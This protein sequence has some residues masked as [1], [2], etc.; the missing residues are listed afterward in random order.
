MLL[1]FLQTLQNYRKW[2]EGEAGQR[3]EGRNEGRTKLP[4]K[5]FSD[6]KNIV[7]YDDNE[8]GK[9][10]N[11]FKVYKIIEIVINVEITGQWRK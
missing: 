1:Q 9:R 8:R 6:S 4:F 11:F 7:H 3:N 2:I 5:Q 10:I